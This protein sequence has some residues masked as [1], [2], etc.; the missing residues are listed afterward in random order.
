MSC[1][2]SKE[3]QAGH[4][5]QHGDTGQDGWMVSRLGALCP[6]KESCFHDLTTQTSGL[7]L[8]LQVFNIPLKKKKKKKY[9][10]VISLIFL[11]LYFE[12][13]SMS[14][15]MGLHSSCSCLNL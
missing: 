8:N 4:T 5:E 11:S 13:W 14:L 2:F 6:G 15:W 12:T 7:R 3:A 9:A 10:A 1:Q